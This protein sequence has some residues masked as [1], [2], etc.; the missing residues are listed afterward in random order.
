[1]KRTNIVFIFLGLLSFS[2]NSCN[3]E[4]DYV[5]SR[6][7][8]KEFDL[9]NDLINEIRIQYYAMTWDGIGPNGTGDLIGAEIV[10]INN[11]KLLIK[12]DLGSLFSPLKDTIH[13]QMKVPYFWELSSQQLVEI[14]TYINKWPKEWTV[15]SNEINDFYYLAFTKTTDTKNELGW[16]KIQIDK[17]TGLIEIKDTKISDQDFLIIG[18]K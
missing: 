1:M 10:P 9:N 3:K 16:V 8:T 7:E 15:L 2:L 18:K 4:T 13:F 11:T 5:P 12:Q 17:S 14:K 6:Q